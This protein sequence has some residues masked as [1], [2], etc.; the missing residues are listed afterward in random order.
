[1][2]SHRAGRSSGR[3]D[4]VRSRRTRAEP[5]V[6]TGPLARAGGVLT[7]PTSFGGGADRA[8]VTSRVQ[9]VAYGYLAVMEGYRHPERATVWSTLTVT[10]PCQVPTIVVDHRSALGRPGVA[11]G[12]GWSMPVGERRFDEEYVVTAAD[13]TTVGPLFTGRLCELLVEHTVQR[14]SFDRRRLLL[15]TFDGREPTAPVLER[16]SALAGDVLAVTPAFVV[17]VMGASEPSGPPTPFPP[18][19][20]G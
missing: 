7:D 2:G 16:L 12:G 9:T 14:L 15:R 13:S 5:I 19:L 6:A 8:E 20:Y 18:G 10:L 1:V 3:A 4:S 11:P 17:R